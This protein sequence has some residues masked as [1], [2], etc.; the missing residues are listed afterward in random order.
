VKGIGWALRDISR[1][2]KAAVRDFLK[3]NPN[4]GYVAVKEAK[5]YL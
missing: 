3:K 4:L 1:F 5:R 2:N